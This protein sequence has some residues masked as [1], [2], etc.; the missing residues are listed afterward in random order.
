MKDLMKVYLVTVAVLK[1]GM[2]FILGTEVS[3]PSDAFEDL[4][5]VKNP[6]Q[7]VFWST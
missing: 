6:K 5:S 3:V 4:G 1:A 2:S 7:P